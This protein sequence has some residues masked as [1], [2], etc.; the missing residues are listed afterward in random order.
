MCRLYTDMTSHES[1]VDLV[2]GFDEFGADY[3]AKAPNRP[4]RIVI[5]SMARVVRPKREGGWRV[6]LMR[7]GLVPHWAKD[8]ANVAGTLNARSETVATLPT[9]RA[10]FK[11]KRCLVPATGWVDWQHVEVEGRKTPRKNPHLFRRGNGGPLLLAG[12]WE[13]WRPQGAEGGAEPLLTY[14]IVTRDP[15][16]YCAQ[17]H[18]RMPVPIEP[19]DAERWCSGTP[20]EAADLLGPCRTGIVAVPVHHDIGSDKRA[21]AANLDPIG[22]PLPDV[23]AVGAAASEATGVAP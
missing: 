18:D 7:W 16:P 6:D 3:D 17:L 11:A 5:K 14:T 8:D 12:L 2:R 20:E 4:Y 15:T 13:A 19:E 22:P 1:V 21:V 23:Q 9:F 10:A